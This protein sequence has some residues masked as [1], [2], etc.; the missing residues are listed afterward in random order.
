M[1]RVV[2][3]AFANELAGRKPQARKRGAKRK[4]DALW[5]S[6]KTGRYVSEHYAKTHP[7]AVT[8]VLTPNS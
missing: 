7:L 1:E 4:P 3:D 8:K 6:N 2:N 5:R